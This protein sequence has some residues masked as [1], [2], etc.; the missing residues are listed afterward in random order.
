MKNFT[1]LKPKEVYLNRLFIK[2]YAS[3]WRNIGLELNITSEALDITEANNPKNVEECC[4]EMLKVWLQ[5]DTEASWEKLLHAVEAGDKLHEA[6]KIL[7][8][9]FV[10]KETSS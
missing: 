2:K 1:E 7:V 4:R 10:A 9:A 5:E 8:L 6:G 3:R